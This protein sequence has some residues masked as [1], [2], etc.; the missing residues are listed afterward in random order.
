[1]VFVSTSINVFFIV[2]ATE[3]IFDVI[4]QIDFILIIYFSLWLH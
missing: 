4:N 2:H 3:Y 1:M